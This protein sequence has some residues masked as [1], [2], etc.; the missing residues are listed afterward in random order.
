M[1]A[2][3]LFVIGP[4]AKATVITFDDLVGSG[5]LA[6]YAGL[7]WTNTS[8][9]DTVQSPYTPHSG[10]QRVYNTDRVSPI[11][12]QFGGDVYF[13]GAWFSGFNPDVSFELYNNGSLVSTSGSVSTSDT[14]AF[15]ASGYGG[16]VDEVRV[17]ASDYLQNGF[18]DYY[19]MDDV[20]YHAV[21]EPAFYQLGALL[22]LGGLGA[23]RLRKRA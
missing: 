1:A 20:T 15:L 16:L 23:L 21:P 17:I 6:S 10:T 12:F 14:P 8:Y 7:T 4:Q 9:Y 11:V 19:T 3:A 18:H 2:F 13:D 22:A 5:S